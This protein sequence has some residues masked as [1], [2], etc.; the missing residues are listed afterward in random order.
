MLATI[1]H[2]GYDEGLT[3]EKTT[4][5]LH[6]RSSFLPSLSAF[7]MQE[8][9]F[10]KPLDLRNPFVVR[11]WNQQ[12]TPSFSVII[13]RPRNNLVVP[14]HRHLPDVQCLDDMPVLLVLHV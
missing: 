14:P 6:A 4:I 3:R 5:G 12:Y 13:W 7:A 9:L 8:L 11:A 2:A 10:A 1:I